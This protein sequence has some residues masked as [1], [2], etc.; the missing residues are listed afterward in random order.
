MMRGMGRTYKR[1]SVWWIAFWHGGKMHRESSQSPSDPT[2]GR[3]ES[4]ANALLRKRLGEIGR[5]KLI[6]ARAEKVTFQELKA[7]LLTDYKIN[8]K[9]STR[10]VKLS[11]SHLE[12]FFATDR[13]MEIRTDRIKIISTSGKTKARRTR[14][15]T[16]N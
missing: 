15:S 13:A 4:D 14:A 10:S 6:G 8:D 12:K 3:R 1:G 2:S 9:R 5:G 7:D 11:V 16:G